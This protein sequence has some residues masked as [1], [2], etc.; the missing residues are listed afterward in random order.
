MMMDG[1]LIDINLRN[2][3]KE[4]E[5]VIDRNGQWKNN[6]MEDLEG[7]HRPKK[8]RGER[9]GGHLREH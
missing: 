9:R 8:G 6:R 7:V 5:E 4:R 1:L 3:S 2:H